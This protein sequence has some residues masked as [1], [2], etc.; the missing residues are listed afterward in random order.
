MEAHNLFELNLIRCHAPSKVSVH[1]HA[2]SVCVFTRSNTHPGQFT[3]LCS[4]V[5]QLLLSACGFYY[6]FYSFSENLVFI[7]AYLTMKQDEDFG[8]SSHWISKIS[9]SCSS[10]C[11]NHGWIVDTHKLWLCWLFAI[12]LHWRKCKHW[13]T[14]I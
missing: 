11:T 6:L 2:C 9:Y 3:E 12:F 14:H 7:A 10:N 8:L 13:V 5:M 1:T 4:D